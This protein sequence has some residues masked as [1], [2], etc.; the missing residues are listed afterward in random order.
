MRP[1]VI[2]R[3]QERYRINVERVVRNIV[4]RI[5]EKFMDGLSD[6]SLLDFGRGDYPMCRYISGN[7]G[8]KLRRIEMYLDNPDFTGI[9][10]V[11]PLAVNIHLIL[12]INQHIKYL[13]TRTDDPEI[14][15]INTSGVDHRWMYLGIWNPLLF[16][17]K[18]FDCLIVGRRFF[19][20]FLKQL[21][22][23]L[24]G[25]ESGPK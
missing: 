5:P 15:S 13:K 21:A 24:S 9:P 10:F 23:K 11:S 8:S 12:A 19:K 18:P 16:V 14:L 3:C 6:I 25:G 7:E 22:N 1:S 20:F 17:F 2:N 4:S